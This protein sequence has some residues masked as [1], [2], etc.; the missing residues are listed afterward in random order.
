MPQTFTSTQAKKKAACL[1]PEDLGRTDKE[2][3]SL[4]REKSAKSIMS[5]WG[6][7]EARQPLAD[8]DPRLASRAMCRK[9][10]KFSRNIN[11]AIR[12]KGYT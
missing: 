9:R 8:I 2:E 7:L 11:H 3:Q 12:W 4:A 1:W 5:A 6:V 10:G